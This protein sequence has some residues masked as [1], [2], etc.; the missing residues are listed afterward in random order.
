VLTLCVAMLIASEFM[1]VSLL[2]PIAADLRIIEGQASQAIAVSGIFAVP[3]SLCISPVPCGIDRRSVL[4][5][6]TIGMIASGLVVALA[7]NPTVFMSGRALLGITIGG[8]WS[9]SAAT[10]MRLV[11]E[12]LV[13]RALAVFK[14]LGNYDRC[15]LG[16]FS[17]AVE[18]SFFLGRSTRSAAGW[19]GT[20]APV[21][22]WT[23]LSKMLPHDAGMRGRPHGRG[24]PTGDHH[25]RYH[26]RLVP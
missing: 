11:P 2:T 19:L 23:W 13:P 8:F 9:M 26:W 24:D 16:K 14:R 25:R 4:L 20:A 1:P 10:A 5:S 7:P 21:G 17:G 12:A 3:A 18:G 6:F 22:W 15:G